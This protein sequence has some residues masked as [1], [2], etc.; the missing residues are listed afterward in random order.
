MS[1]VISGVRRQT[2][3]YLNGLAGCRSVDE[4]LEDTLAPRQVERTI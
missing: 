2:E 4:I 3:I 1:G